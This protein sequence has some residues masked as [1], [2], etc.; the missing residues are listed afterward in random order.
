MSNMMNFAEH[1]IA[2]ANNNDKFITNLQLQKVMYFSMKT[3]NADK[4]FLQNLYDEPFKVW[5]YGPVVKSVYDK[6]KIFVSSPII[7]QAEIV[8][9]YNIFNDEILK[10]LDENPFD[11]VNRSHKEK[12]WK[13]NKYKIVFSTSDIEY[14]L[15]YVRINNV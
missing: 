2:V 13:Y 1:I 8:E 5:R 9:D 10:F 4:K 11:L 3:V 6:Y 7:A 15:E 14:S 12:K